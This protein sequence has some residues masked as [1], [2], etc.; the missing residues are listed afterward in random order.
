MTT[1]DFI[2]QNR[3]RFLDELFDLLRIPSVSADPAYAGDVRKCAEAVADSLRKAGAAGV[4][5]I[6]TGGYPVVYVERM[7]DPAAP[8]VLVYALYDVQPAD[9]IDLW[10]TP[11]FEP[12][13]QHCKSK[14]GRASGGLKY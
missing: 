1:N 5:L 7:V 9:P 6:E 10:D 3:D 13:I 14:L 8:T 11:S 12:E 4:E 2:Q